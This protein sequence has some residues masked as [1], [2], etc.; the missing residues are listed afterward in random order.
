MTRWG[1]VDAR[2][3]AS[4]N[5][6]L[7]FVLGYCQNTFY[8]SHQTQPG[9]A[10]GASPTVTRISSA[11]RHQVAA[12]HGD[13][14][15]K[16][17]RGTCPNGW[18]RSATE[19]ARASDTRCDA[20]THLRAHQRGYVVLAP[21]TLNGGT[22]PLHSL[23]TTDRYRTYA[24]PVRDDASNLIDGMRPDSMSRQHSRK[25]NGSVRVASNVCR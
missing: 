21:L 12:S 3:I 13:K 17:G 9:I 18:R 2:V 11:A 14:F 5:E 15:Q 1:T 19:D 20:C 16:S 23:G 10:N 4:D 22:W 7:F 25:R 6:R 8:T 24:S